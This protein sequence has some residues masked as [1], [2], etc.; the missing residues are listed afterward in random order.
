[1]IIKGT[2]RIRVKRDT[3][4]VKDAFEGGGVKEQAAVVG[5]HE[6]SLSPA[7]IFEAGSRQEVYK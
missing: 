7:T 4:I 3:M 2:L 6:Q 5:F 1:M